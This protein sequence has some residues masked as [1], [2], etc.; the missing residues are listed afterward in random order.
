WVVLAGG[1]GLFLTSRL[2]ADR[3]SHRVGEARGELNKADAAVFGSLGETLEA[4][5]DLRLW[6]AREQ[7]ARE[8]ADVAHAAAAA[9]ARFATALAVSGQI[10]SVFTALAP[11]LIIVA[12]KLS[13]RSYGPG[14]VA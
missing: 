2:L 7:A 5:E 8:F 12:L 9:R 14:E 6:G 4:S 1:V 11:L 10:K 13:G 3:T